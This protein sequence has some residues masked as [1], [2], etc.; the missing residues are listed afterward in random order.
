MEPSVFSLAK[1]AGLLFARAEFEASVGQGA[2]G[3]IRLT[4]ERGCS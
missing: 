1:L 2:G 3:D 4:E